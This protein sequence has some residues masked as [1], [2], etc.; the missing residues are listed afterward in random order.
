MAAIGSTGIGLS[1]RE[2]SLTNNCCHWHDCHWFVSETPNLVNNGCD[3]NVTKVSLA[4]W[5][6]LS[7]KKN[8]IGL[9]MAV[10][11]STDIG[12]SEKKHNWAYN[13]CHWLN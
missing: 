5:H 7:S 8:L 4:Q 13:G 12:L 3:W 11:S 9:I 10:N 2:L 1:V 6:W